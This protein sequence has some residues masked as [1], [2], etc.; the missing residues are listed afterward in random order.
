MCVAC[1][2]KFDIIRVLNVK[3]E[4]EDLMKQIDKDILC[5]LCGSHIAVLT[6]AGFIQSTMDR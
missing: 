6:T 1:G 3:C 2:G 5:T 4:N